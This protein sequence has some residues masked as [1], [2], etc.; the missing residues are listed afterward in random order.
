MTHKADLIFIVA[1]RDGVVTMQ[2]ESSKISDKRGEHDLENVKAV[3]DG[4]EARLCI[5]FSIERAWID[6]EGIHQVLPRIDV[7][8]QEE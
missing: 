4:T 8:L 3:P 6:D 2:L 1:N 5:N 7:E